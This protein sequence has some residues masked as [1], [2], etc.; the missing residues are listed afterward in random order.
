[1]G[2]ALGGW[3][4]SLRILWPGSRRTSLGGKSGLSRQRM[5]LHP[6]LRRCQRLHYDA[7]APDD[8]ELLAAQ[9]DSITDAGRVTP[10][11]T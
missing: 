8:V 10:H 5:R 11:M 3:G 4:P 7:P 6:N 1:M 2:V 9:H